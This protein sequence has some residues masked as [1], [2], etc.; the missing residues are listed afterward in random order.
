MFPKKREVSFNNEFHNK[1]LERCKS[2]MS[3]LEAYKYAKVLPVSRERIESHD[4]GREIALLYVR[5]SCRLIMH[6]KHEVQDRHVCY[7]IL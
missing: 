2:T 5:L 6:C 3:E 1:Y 7:R 4:P